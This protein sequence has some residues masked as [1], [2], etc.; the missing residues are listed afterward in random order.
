M[1]NVYKVVESPPGC[2]VGFRDG[3]IVITTS[4]PRFI[5]R[6]LDEVRGPKCPLGPRDLENA[7][8]GLAIPV[9]ASPVYEEAERLVG[10]A[11]QALRTLGSSRYAIG[12]NFEPSQ[13]D[14]VIGP[15]QHRDRLERLELLQR[16]LGA[17]RHAIFVAP[18]GGGTGGSATA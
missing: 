15:L 6:W 18:Q 11:L 5:E 16:E 7:V 9:I 17:I 13:A 14:Q 2:W 12:S 4:N 1:H 3:E 10:A 8:R